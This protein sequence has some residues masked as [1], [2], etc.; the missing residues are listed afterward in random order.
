MIQVF[1]ANYLATTAVVILLLL[2]VTSISVVLLRRLRFIQ[3]PLVLVG[4]DEALVSAGVLVAMLLLCTGVVPGIFRSG[5]VYYQN[6]SGWIKPFLMIVAELS[7]IM[8]AFQA[9]LFLLIKLGLL[10]IGGKFTAKSADENGAAISYW[11]VAVAIG[12]SYIL[13]CLLLLIA[14]ERVPRLIRMTY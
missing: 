1:Q 14:D 3:K 4:N 9:I 13:R 8:L 11:L 10:L 12:S 5:T 2:I 7:G 6:T